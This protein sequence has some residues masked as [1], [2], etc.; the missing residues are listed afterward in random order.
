MQLS[1]GG[2]GELLTLTTA[3]PEGPLPL[4]QGDWLLSGMYVNEL[5]VRLVPRGEG[6]QELFALYERTICALVEGVAIEPLLRRF[7]VALLELCGYGLPLFTVEPDSGPIRPDLRYEFRADHGFVP[8][9]NRMPAGSLAG[10]TILALGGL[11]EFSPDALLE[12]KR[13][14]RG[15]LRQYLGDKPL[16]ARSLFQAH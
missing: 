16:H 5:L 10:A 2:R 8:V 11:H 13:F 1:F 6:D 9:G 7:E 3:E 4:L 12:A 15:V 14:M